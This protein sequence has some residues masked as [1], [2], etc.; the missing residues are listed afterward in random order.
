MIEMAIGEKI[1][2]LR[3]EKGPIACLNDLEHLDMKTGR[4]LSMFLKASFETQKRK[5]PII[6]MVK[7]LEKFLWKHSLMMKK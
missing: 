4:S 2:W 7:T 3:K 1:L 5:K 6:H